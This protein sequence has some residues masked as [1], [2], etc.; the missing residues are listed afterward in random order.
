MH[1]FINTA[2][3]LLFANAVFAQKFESVSIRS[4][5]SIAN[6]KWYYKSIDLTIKDDV[7]IGLYNQISCDYYYNS[8]INFR[9]DLGHF[10]KGHSK[11][12]SFSTPNNPD[13]IGEFIR[14]KTKFDFINLSPTVVFK[15]NEKKWSPYFLLGL[16]AD[17]ILPSKDLLDID[18]NY[19]IKNKVYFGA[20]PGFGYQYKFKNYAIGSEILY[21]YDFSKMYDTEPTENNTGLSITNYTGAVNLFF[22]YYFD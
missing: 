8:K 2:I 20:T 3:I 7:L 17:Y 6:Q 4:G 22:K 10:Q 18:G 12:V 9:L 5:F 19:M 21:L 14:F 16:R 15:L 13:G 11:T 1:R